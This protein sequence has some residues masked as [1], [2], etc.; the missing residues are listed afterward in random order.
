M[1]EGI[2]ELVPDRLYRL[3]GTVEADP[4]IS[5]L[6]PGREGYEPINAY[7]LL[8]GSR[9]V[10]IDTG[11][12]LH[13]DLIVEQLRELLPP[14]PRLSVFLTRIEMDCISNLARVAEAF[15]VE[16]VHAGGASN[17]FDFFDDL[18]SSA[19]ATKS[20]RLERIAGDGTLE[21]SD[22][23]VM[24]VLK[25]KLRL[26]ST[27]WAFDEATGALFT[28]DSFGYVGVAAAGDAPISSNGSRPSAAAVH[29][30]MITK[31]DFLPAANTLDIRAGVAEIFERH[32]VRIIAPAHG[33]V[34]VGA[35][36]ARD[37]L[38]LVDEALS[39]CGKEAR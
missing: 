7:L 10:L 18:E 19:I 20:A 23:R 32:D 27:T 5:W 36:L 13:G 22:S 6:P 24:R 35:E 8:E 11:V 15:P 30:H 16:S 9:A 38:E 37:H 17:P 3:G 34:L 21:L 4:L 31:F 25:T 26:L 2:L 14:D 29:E 28:S 39:M 12:A 33:C 1:K